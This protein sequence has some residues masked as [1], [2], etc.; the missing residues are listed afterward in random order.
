MLMPLLASAAIPVQQSAGSSAQ[1]PGAEKR[2]MLRV[3]S[4]MEGAGAPLNLVGYVPNREIQGVYRLPLNVEEDFELLYSDPEFVSTYSAVEVDGIY[5]GTRLNSDGTVTVLG[6]NARTWEPVKILSATAGCCGI[7]TAY[8][9]VS[10]LVYGCFM[11]DDMQGTVF[12]Y[13]DYKNAG[14]SLERVKI[15]DLDK[16]L[17]GVAIDAEGNVFGIT[18]NGDLYSVN[19]STGELTF[20][21]A[22]DLEDKFMTSATIDL[23]TGKMYYAVANEGFGAL[24]EVDVTTGDANYVN[25]FFMAEEIIGMSVAKPEVEEEAPAAVAG[26]SLAF[27]KDATKGKCT[28]T[29]PKTLY[30]GVAASGAL[31]YTVRLKK[32]D[33]PSQVIATGNT[34]F[35]GSVSCDVEVPEDGLYEFW[36]YVSN[37]VGD[38]KITKQTMFVGHD[39]PLSPVITRAVYAN[40]NTSL[41]WEPVTESLNGG[42]FLPEAM[43]YTVTRLS[44]NKVVASDIAATTLEDKVGDVK[45]LTVIYYRVT[46][47]DGART[48]APAK[49]PKLVAGVADL[50][51]VNSF[52]NESAFDFLTCIDDNGD[53]KTWQWS[54]MYEGAAKLPYT[55][56]VTSDDWLMLPGLYLEQ[57]QSYIISYRPFGGD[58]TETEKYEVKYGAAAVPEF[59]TEVILPETELRT[60]RTKSEMV[61]HFITPSESGVWYIGFHGMSEHDRFNLYIDDLTVSEGLTADSPKP[62]TELKVVSAAEGERAATVTFTAPS[63]KMNGQKLESITEVQ[64]RRDGRL[65]ATLEDVVPGQEVSYEDTK[66]LTI[67][68]HEWTVVVYSGNDVSSPVSASTHVGFDF[69]RPVTNI[70][71]VEG[72]E[73]GVV[74]ITWD[75]VTEDVRGNRLPVGKVTYT[76]F[77]RHEINTPLASGLTDNSLTCRIELPEG[78]QQ[79]FRQFMVVPVTEAGENYDG[80]MSM[81]IPVGKPFDCPYIESFPNQDASYPLGLM[82]DDNQLMRWG[83]YDSGVFLDPNGNGIDVYD[84]DHG[85]AVFFGMDPGCAADMLSPKIT[86]PEE[87]PLLTFYFYPLSNNDVN[88]VHVIVVS[89]EGESEVGTVVMNTTGPALQWNRA[90]IDLSA[91]AGKVVSLRFRGVTRSHTRLFMDRVQVARGAEKDLAL[92]TIKAPGAVHPGVEFEIEF[93]V[94][95]YGKVKADNY[96]IQLLRNGVTVKAYE[97]ETI[98]PGEVIT[99]KVP[100]S[101]SAIDEEENVYYAYVNYDGDE[102]TSNDATPDAIVIMRNNPYPPVSGLQAEVGDEGVALSWIEPDI[103]DMVYEPFTE[104]FETGRDWQFEFEGWSFVDM[105]GGVMGAFDMAS[106]PD[107]TPADTETNFFVFNCAGSAFPE[108]WDAHSGTRYLACVYNYNEVQNDDWAISPLL[109]GIEQE[110]SFYAKSYNYN[111]LEDFEVLY[112]TGDFDPDNFDPSGFISIDKRIG[113][114]ANWK[115][116]TFTLPEGARYFAIRC[117][118]NDAMMLMVDDVTYIADAGADGIAHMGY[119][120]YR[121]GELLNDAFVEETRFVDPKT[122]K[123]RHTYSVTAVYDLGE[124]VPADVRV[125]PSSVEQLAN[126]GI[127]IEV[128]NGAVVI[129][130]AEG[131]HIIVAD[132]EGRIH[133]SGVADAT[134]V[135]PLTS[136]TYV[137]TAG[138]ATRKLHLR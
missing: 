100:T 23:K 63:E 57:G 95:N 104:D 11:A 25:Q 8:D 86:L 83:V 24:Y 126:E 131:R 9:P 45:D 113:I 30:N 133:F 98:A 135:V 91:Y 127:V 21:G 13:I 59:M 33:L 115:R 60:N 106:I 17:Y 36:V 71:A 77:E 138:P 16:V 72:P 121:D 94:A 62:V 134:T 42:Y 14:K 58:S 81:A 108:T 41:S 111:Y 92:T 88:E 18:N 34:T 47:S 22:T 54:D 123:R 43:T 26:L 84:Y 130:G 52:D 68:T 102:D 80:K 3:P 76:V 27:D 125:D 73:E 40:G 136:G 128:V 116:Y 119:N 61:Q 74:T 20:I 75:P 1:L 2:Q 101:L 107:M 55:G 79:A 118:S 53:E 19:K 89:P 78:V 96:T 70:K 110:I 132:V 51:Y 49:S 67:G 39:T 105:D 69:A 7:D 6:L 120:V 124:S 122:D 4:L 114:E 66:E 56:I 29:A 85:M 117:I 112:T 35:G 48:S 99:I 31:S 90:A 129:T 37:S 64:I 65:I 82:S 28:F 103:N 109:P 50:P 97:G 87:N 44:D 32:G 137:V 15:A 38:G 5:Y 10:G 46:A 12:G 93:G